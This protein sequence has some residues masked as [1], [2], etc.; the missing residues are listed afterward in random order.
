MDF[1]LF[2]GCYQFSNI[3]CE[4]VDIDNEMDY[5][6]VLERLA[7]LVESGDARLFGAIWHA[8]LNDKSSYRKGYIDGLNMKEKLKHIDIKIEE[9]N[10]DD[11]N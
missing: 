4:A 9:A 7:D 6:E 1:G 5:D 8:L 11:A 10:R 2:D 3:V